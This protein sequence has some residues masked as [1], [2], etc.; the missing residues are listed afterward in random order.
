MLFPGR[1]YIARSPWHSV[2][3]RNIFCQIKVKTKKS[4]TIWARGPGTV[5]HAKYGAGYCITFMKSLDEGLR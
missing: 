1:I 2:D 3:F 4:R 5:P